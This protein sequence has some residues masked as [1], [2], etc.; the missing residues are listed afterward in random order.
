LKQ[1]SGSCKARP[2]ARRKNV[3]FTKRP[4]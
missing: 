2:S 1:S 3:S 4:T